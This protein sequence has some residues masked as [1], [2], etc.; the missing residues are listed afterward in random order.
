MIHIPLIR[1][2][3]R[4]WMSIVEMEK[5]KFAFSLILNVEC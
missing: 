3:K 4:L 1:K 2:D 5:Y